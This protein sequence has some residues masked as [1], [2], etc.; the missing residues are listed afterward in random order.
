MKATL[1]YP[2][3]LLT[4][5]TLVRSDM[6]LSDREVLGSNPV[7]ISD[8]CYPIRRGELWRFSRFSGEDQSSMRNANVRSILLT[9]GIESI[10]GLRQMES[11]N[12]RIGTT[13][14]SRTYI[15][16]LHTRTASVTD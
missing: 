11:K 9:Y 4:Y 16:Y 13:S 14:Y 8:F 10:V 15:L 7:V 12:R 5:K 6:T 3:T 2:L 1:K